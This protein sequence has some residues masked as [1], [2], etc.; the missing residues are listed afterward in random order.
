METFEAERAEKSVKTAAQHY[1]P[2]PD[3]L[4]IVQRTHMT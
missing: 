1:D 2:G 4:L 3:P